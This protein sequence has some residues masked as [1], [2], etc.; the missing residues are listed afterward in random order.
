MKWHLLFSSKLKKGHKFL[1]KVKELYEWYTHSKKHNLNFYLKSQPATDVADETIIV[2]LLFT[3]STC[4]VLVCI[5]HNTY[6]CICSSRD[7]LS[8]SADNQIIFLGQC[9]WRRLIPYNSWMKNHWQIIIIIYNGQIYSTVYG[10]LLGFDWLSGKQRLYLESLMYTTISK[11]SAVCT[12]K[13]TL[14]KT[15]IFTYIAT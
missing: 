15:L 3:Y 2:H 14:L 8:F 10:N 4:I 5:K 11:R 7:R 1:L 13:K 9:S 6:C 12:V